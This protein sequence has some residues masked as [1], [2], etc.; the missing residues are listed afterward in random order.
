MDTSQQSKSAIDLI[1]NSVTKDIK[2]LRNF[3][4]RGQ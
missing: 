2:F 3:E 1:F 4:K